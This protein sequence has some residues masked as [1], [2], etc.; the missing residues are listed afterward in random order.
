MVNFFVCLS[1]FI[2]SFHLL[3]EF[4]LTWNVTISDEGCTFRTNTQ[5]SWALSSEG[6][7]ACHKYCEMGHPFI[8][9]SSRDTHISCQAFKVELS[10]PVNDLG[11]SRHGFE[12]PSACRTQARPDCFTSAGMSICKWINMCIVQLYVLIQNSQER[13]R[14]NNIY[15]DI[16]YLPWKFVNASKRVFVTQLTEFLLWLVIF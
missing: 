9:I 14:Q 2:L 12:H 16:K 15:N 8:M 6:Y 5:Q 13:D 7:F 4:S 1:L 11:L 10:I 3:G